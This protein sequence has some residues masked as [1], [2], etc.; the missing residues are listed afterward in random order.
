M[1]FFHWRPYK[2]F[3]GYTFL[4]TGNFNRMRKTWGLHLFVL[5]IV[6]LAKEENVSYVKV[7]TSIAKQ[8]A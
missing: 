5:N 8:V 1:T 2:H 6:W 7:R 4:F 3:E